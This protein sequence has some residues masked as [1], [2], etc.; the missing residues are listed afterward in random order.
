MRV[1]FVNFGA[2]YR[3]H[4]E[5]Y[6]EAIFKC[7]NEGKLILQEDVEEFEGNLAKFLGMKY[8]V[9]TSSGTDALTLALKAKR[10]IYPELRAGS[11]RVDIPGYTFKATMEAAS[12][13]GYSPIISDITRDRLLPENRAVGTSVPVYRGRC[14]PV[15]IE[16]S[17]CK[18]KGTVLVEDACQAIGARG[19]GYSGTA[20]YSFYPA[21]ILGGFGDGGA[22]VTN[23][24]GVAD[25]VRL[26][27]H[28]WQTDKDEE[29]GFC[30]RLDNVQAAFLNVKLKYLPGILERRQKIAEMYL[31]ALTDV[32]G[33]PVASVERVWQDFVCTVEN[34]KELQ[35]HLKKNG[36]ETLGVGMIPPHIALNTG[37]SL[38]NTEKLYREMI[39]LPLNETLTDD[40]V[41]YVISKVNELYD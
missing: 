20:C 16:G 39:R 35:E 7:L 24:K 31:E 23:D 4:K 29:Y 33:L 13:A 28:H 25:E 27:R 6:D 12:H 40:D 37:Q 18:A 32:V 38:P 36:I 3:Q 19:V 34:P 8:A 17:V 41:N 21:K 26:L 10:R 1:D 2:Q 9:G 30:S 22:V 14:I 5:E 15:H 11:S